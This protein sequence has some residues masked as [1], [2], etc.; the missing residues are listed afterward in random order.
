MNRVVEMALHCVLHESQNS[1]HGEAQLGIVEF[2]IINS[3]SQSTGYTPF[4]LNLDIT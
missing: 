2:V 1:N 3:P 4:F